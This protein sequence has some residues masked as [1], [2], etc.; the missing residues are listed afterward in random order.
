MP[1]PFVDGK[2]VFLAMSIDV[3]LDADPPGKVSP[4]ACADVKPKRL[5]NLRAVSFSITVR[6]GETT[7]VW[8]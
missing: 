6:A 1:S 4:P 5:A 2:S 7:G 3:E 8:R